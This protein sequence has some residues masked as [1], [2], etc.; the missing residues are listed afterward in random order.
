MG[1]LVARIAAIAV[2]LGLA[3]LGLALPGSLLLGGLAWLCVL[4]GA[5][6]GWG[7]FVVRI[8]RV[9]DPDIG[10][11][12]AWGVAAYLAVAGVLLMLGIYSQP[13]VLAAVGIGVVGFAWR[14]IVTP[15]PLL[16]TARDGLAALRAQP[17]L[18]AIAIVLGAAVLVQMLGG[19]AHL[20]RNPWDDDI[21]YT[22]MIRR[23]LDC[24]DLIEPFSFRRLASYGGQPVLGALVGARGSLASVHMLDQTL[25]YGL[26]FMLVVGHARQ[27]GASALSL[28]LVVAVLLFAPD[29]SLNTASYWSGAVMFIALYRTTVA[30]HF[31]IAAIVAAATCTLRQNYI[32]VAG[33]FLLLTLMSA[34]VPRMTWFRSLAVVGVVML[35][36]LIAA[37]ISSRTFLFPVI[38]G[39]WNHGLTLGPSG[40]NWVD[41]LSL[42]LVTI[43]DSQ[44]IVI[45]LVF[46]PLV[47]VTTDTRRTRPLPALLA[48]NLIG[49]ALLVVTFSDA[50]PPTMWRYA[51]G[52]TVALF[53]MFTLDAADADSG[54]VKLAPL[55]RWVL[56]AALVIQLMSSRSGHVK[57]Y[58]RMLGDIR[59]VAAIEGK[60]DPNAQVEARRHAAM[61]A[62]VPVGAPLLVMLDDPGFLDFARNR[63]AN[64]D[65]PGFASPGTQWPHFVGPEPVRAYLLA[66]GYRYV[67]YVRSE[68]SRYAFRRGFWLWRVFNDI[69]F[70]QAMSAYTIDV[71]DT[72]EY[73]ATTSHILYDASGLVVLD[74]ERSY[75]KPRALDP[76]GERVRRDAFLRDLAEQEGFAAEWS[77]TTRNDVVFADGLSGL[78]FAQPGDNAKW[79]EVAAIDPEP[80]RG[81]PVR[82][83][84]RRTHLRVRGSRDMHLVLRGR[85]N[86]GVLYARPRLDVSINGTLLGSTLVAPDGAFTIDLTVPAAQLAG[87]RWSDLYVLFNA[88]GQPE[89]DARDV[90]IASLESVTWEPR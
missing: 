83:M 73:F 16:A 28:V 20:D 58:A 51:F 45:M 30:N 10:L 46:I 80:K 1:G 29:I 79:F 70:F 76:A 81:V 35:P 49:F 77:L 25:C 72:F 13:V 43:I 88:I 90:R 5:L 55:G 63:I 15:S 23:L 86:I 69:E 36:W 56:L 18:A 62:V 53:C 22:P 33:L 78:T 85:V 9:E 6:S 54:P 8:A 4:L 17:L 71:I 21:A 7:W 82:W 26:V 47:A 66:N 87:S 32:P 68:A 11:R 31:I 41:K 75:E 74:I 27:Q 59:E 67:A 65:V 61:Q 50:D 19:I 89:R 14:E 3:V 84:Y 38:E 52:Y 39:T 64:L 24:G 44:P 42:L 37:S 34:R 12:V 40:W 60:G 2:L 48:A 57:R